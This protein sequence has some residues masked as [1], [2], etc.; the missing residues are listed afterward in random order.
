M[1]CQ[2]PPRG[3]Q[4][5]NRHWHISQFSCSCLIHCERRRNL[6][7]LLGLDANDGSKCPICCH[8]LYIARFHEVVHTEETTKSNEQGKERQLTR[9]LDHYRKHYHWNGGCACCGYSYQS[10]RRREDSNDDSGCFDTTTL[11]ISFGLPCYTLENRRAQTIV[12]WLRTT[13]HLH[14]PTMGLNVRHEREIYATLGREEDREVGEVDIVK[15]GTC[16]ALL[17]IE[18]RQCKNSFTRLGK[19][20]V[21][22]L[23]GSN[24]VSWTSHRFRESWIMRADKRE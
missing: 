7:F 15:A 3:N 19:R 24:E 18:R 2:R 11:Q 16:L 10:R 9:E 6:G 22:I 8:H 23:V 21:S 12:C 17:F 20:K 4:A 5:E 1:Y 14:V 13:Q